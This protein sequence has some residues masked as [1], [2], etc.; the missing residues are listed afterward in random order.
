MSSISNLCELIDHGLNNYSGIVASTKRKG[1]WYDT[2]ITSFKEQLNACAAGFYSL[3]VRKGDRVAIHSENSTEWL[4]IDYALLSLG[5]TSVPIYTTQPQAQIL[6]ILKDASV[7]GYAVS[8]QNLYD[9]CPAQM[10]S[11]TPSLKWMV[12]IQ[13]KF[14]SEMM[15]LGDVMTR[16]K[17]QLSETPDLISQT[18]SKIQ[19]EDL[20]TICY[21]SGTTGQPKGV[22]LTHRNLTTNAMSLG[23]RLTFD[24]PCNVLS[25][26][27]LSHSFERIASLFYIFKS[28]AIY[29]IE[30]PDELMDDIQHIRP[31]HMTTVPRLLE[32]VHSA[33]MTKAIETTGIQGQVALW[34]FNK[35]ENYD[36]E[37]PS[38]SLSDKIADSLVYKKARARFG[39][40]LEAITSGGAALS[41]KVQSFINGIGI[42]CG[43]GYGLTETSPVITLYERGKLR[44]GSVGTPIQDVQVKIAEE[45]GEILTK[46]P[47]IMA[48]Y[49]NLPDE[50]AQTISE[51]GWLHTGDIG[52]I[53]EDGYLHITDRKKQLFKLSTGKYIAPAPIEVALASSALIEH[54]VVVGPD[55]KFCAALIVVDARYVEQALG[56]EVDSSVLEREVQTIID[57]VNQDLPPWE[58]IKK[59][60]VIHD[61]FT[62]DGGQ[63]TPTLK[64]R[65]KNIFT[66]FKDEIDSMY[67]S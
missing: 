3:G 7:C 25:F 64:V 35:A 13:D 41:P 58:Q 19:H 23:D 65:R 24:V 10:M 37:N 8:S 55:F 9:R 18:K 29:F 42:Y 39:G 2:D 34:A 5:A 27:P 15:T 4:L 61:P 12:G 32:K 54:A 40:N 6:Y 45:D 16:G 43:Q 57:D 50:T 20:A 33:M 1:T 53:D 21:T 11:D 63:L 28:C 66:Q 51:D 48:G 46:G 31:H 36:I 47:H 44:A 26:L 49:L 60:H 67:T 62:I 17:E 56:K 14:S 38:N 52:K 22:M 30:T 59:F